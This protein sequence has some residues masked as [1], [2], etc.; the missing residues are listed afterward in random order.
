MTTEKYVTQRLLRFNISGQVLLFSV[1]A[2]FGKAKTVHANFS[3]LIKV[4]IE[5]VDNM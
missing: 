5:K 3:N 1:K 2:L 4:G